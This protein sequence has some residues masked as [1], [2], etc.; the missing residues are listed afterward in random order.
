[1]TP[2]LASRVSRRWR[3]HRVHLQRRLPRTD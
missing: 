2:M 1:M 3:A